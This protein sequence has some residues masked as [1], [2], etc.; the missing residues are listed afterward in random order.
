MKG[1]VW[2][3]GKLDKNDLDTLLKCVKK[4]PEV[5]V[6]PMAG[7]DSGVHSIDDKYLV[8]ST[9]PCIG[10]PEEWFGW[11]LIHYAASDVAL[12]GAK[13]QYCAI[14]LLGSSLTKPQT[15]HRI[16]Q[17]TCKAADELQMSIVTGHTGTYDGLATLVGTCTA[18]GII[19][20]HKLITPACA[21]PGDI[22]FC[23]KPLGLETAVNFALTHRT[24]ADKLLGV[25][26]TDELRRQIQM[27]SC[28]KE[29]LLL[30]DANAVHAMHDTTEG[31]LTASLNE[32]ADASKL[33][34]RIDFNKIPIHGAVRLLQNCFQLSDNQVL[35]ISSTGTIIAS[36]KPEAQNIIQ[37]IMSSAGAA[38]KSIGIFTKNKTRILVKDEK[39]TIFPEAAEDPYQ[40]ILSGKV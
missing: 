23:I 38:A 21:K 34:F 10:V 36:A 25:N 35:S 15:F 6:P 14:N 27:Q 8:V 18:Y 13:P 16:M 37:N 40:M 26:Q 2:I 7:F 24:L 3:M 33:G 29:A 39:E 31:G 32:M 19:D 1:K 20:K 12:F 5:V 4:Y 28:V 30:S 9:D 22:I 11:L 17:Q